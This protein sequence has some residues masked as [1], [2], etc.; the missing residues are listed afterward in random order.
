MSTIEETR[1][2]NGAVV[3]DPIN[4]LDTSALSECDKCEIE[5]LRTAYDRG[6]PKAVAEGMARLV[7]SHPDL[8][9][10]LVK[11]LTE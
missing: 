1:F 5:K 4:N 8:F 9:G 11:R 10:W 7:K 3:T 2:S 6:G